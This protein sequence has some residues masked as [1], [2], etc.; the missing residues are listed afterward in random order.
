MKESF[1]QKY[2]PETLSEVKGHPSAIKEIQRWAENWTSGD[3]P[4]ML[5]GPA[6]TGKTSTAEALAND[7]DWSIVEINASSQTRKEDIKYIVQTIRSKSMESEHTLFL[8]DEVDSINGKSLT[9]LSNVLND[10][11]NP[12][13]VT[14]N[15]KWKVPNSISNACN[16]IKF[17]LQK[18]SLKPVLQYI[19]EKEEID[20]SKREIGMLATRNG[21]RDAINDLQEFAE[22]DAD[23][24]WDQRK[25]DIGNFDAVDNLLRGKKFSGEMTPPDIVEWLDENIHTTMDGIE[26]VRAYQC[27]SEADK[28]VQ[29]TNET[30]NYSWWKYAGSVAEEVANIR[31]TE[32]YD[33]INKSYPKARRNKPKKSK[34]QNSEAQLY[35]EIKEHGNFSGAFSYQEFRRT[36]KGYLLELDKNERMQLAL[37]FSLSSEARNELD[38]TDTQYEDWLGN[39]G[40]EETKQESITNFGDKEEEK[41]ESKSIFDF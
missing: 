20:I 14:A 29:R 10:P 41:E 32:P 13:I 5:C 17:N 36:I 28:F 21:L 16:Q 31:I 30:Q 25:T 35:R 34:Y 1:V 9:P 7:M 37:N 23:L 40:E 3:E 39:E 38:I 2:R 12:V 15:E 22:S 11:P 24:D 8:L 6:G 26:A 18:R 27:L 19:A 33:W 4:I